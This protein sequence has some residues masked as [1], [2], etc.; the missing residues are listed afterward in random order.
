MFNED[1]NSQFLA[2]LFKGVQVDPGNPLM[3]ARQKVFSLLLIF[4]CKKV[5]QGSVLCVLETLQVLS[6]A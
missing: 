2:V 1:L 4:P 6:G 5:L 3:P